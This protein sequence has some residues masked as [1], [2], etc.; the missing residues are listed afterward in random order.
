MIAWQTTEDSKALRKQLA[1]SLSFESVAKKYANR[2]EAVCSAS[3]THKCTCPF[4]KNGQERTPSLHL[5]DL[6]KTFFC[7]ACSVSGDIFDFI[8]MI[9]G[10]PGDTVAMKYKES[11]NIS[12]DLTDITPSRTRSNVH[13]I[14]LQISISIR[15]YLTSI[16]DT[17]SYNDDICWSESIFKRM[18]ERF[19]KLTDDD[20]EQ[21][22]NFSLQVMMELERRK[23]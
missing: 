2:I 10:S 18:D 14:N 20:A 4:H 17:G 12:I 19:A 3:W 5:S 6:D 13:E 23:S 7:Y 16:K 22:R 11:K 9:R 15:E 21:A 1:K 8:G